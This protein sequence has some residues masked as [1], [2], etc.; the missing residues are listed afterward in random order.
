MQLFWVLWYHNLLLP[1]LVL[2]ILYALIINRIF[3]YPTLADLRIHRQ[4]VKRADKFGKEV[5][6]RLSSSSV[7][8]VKEVWRMLVMYKRAK[9][10]RIGTAQKR[11]RKSEA[12]KLESHD[13]PTVLDDPKESDD[14]QNIKRAVLCA[15]NE[16][17]D[18]HERVKK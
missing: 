1:A 2:R 10:V 14:E 3:P 18:L 9:K 12:S 4:E 8:K 13:E 11:S 15:I 5:Q 16:T 17:A 7:L 6:A